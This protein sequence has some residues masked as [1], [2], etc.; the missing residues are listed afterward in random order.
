M[1]FYNVFVGLNYNTIS[2]A[3]YR[4]WIG[5]IRP[6]PR[7]SRKWQYRSDTDPE[8]RIGAPLEYTTGNLVFVSETDYV[9]GLMMFKTLFEG[10][11]I[12]P[13]SDLLQCMLGKY[14][15]LYLLVKACT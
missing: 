10:F 8:Y 15:E 6:I 1:L 4:I 2:Y 3:E 11:E 5:L 9:L 12:D 7:S 13:V 14:A